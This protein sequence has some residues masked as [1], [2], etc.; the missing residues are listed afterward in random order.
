[1]P[2]L[3]VL[4]GDARKRHPPGRSSSG[5]NLLHNRGCASYHI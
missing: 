5:L 3:L 2:F 1:L 4:T